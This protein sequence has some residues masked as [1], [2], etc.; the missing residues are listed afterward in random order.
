M[1]SKLPIKN[2]LEFVLNR[3]IYLIGLHAG[4]SELVEARSGKVKPTKRTK[5]RLT[6]NSGGATHPLP[7]TKN[8][9]RW[10]ELSHTYFEPPSANQRRNASVC[11]QQ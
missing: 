3:P 7:E 9:C 1:R 10:C 8:I 2:R 4:L 6:S 5:A 11:S